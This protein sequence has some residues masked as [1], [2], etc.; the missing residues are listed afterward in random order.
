MSKLFLHS[1]NFFVVYARLVDTL[2]LYSVRSLRLRPYAHSFP[3]P[4]LEEALL[5]C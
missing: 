5:S 3:F 1:Y 2:K 4:E